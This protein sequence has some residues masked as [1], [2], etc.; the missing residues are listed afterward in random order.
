[1]AGIYW[2]TQIK[3][4]NPH[5]DLLRVSMDRL[6]NKSPG[7][8]LSQ[9]LPLT[10][11]EKDKIKQT[12]FCLFSLAF[13][14]VCVVQRC[15]FVVMFCLFIFVLCL[16]ITA[17]SLWGWFSSFCHSF[18]LSLFLLCSRWAQGVEQSIF[19]FEL[20]CIFYSLYAAF[21]VSVLVAFFFIQ[22]S[23]S[24]LQYISVRC[25]CVCL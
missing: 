9:G 2:Q 12:S 16:V 5:N 18:V 14:C 11:S 19:E 25:V 24:C 1:M 7:L 22:F 23:L 21:F 4:S 17:L 13:L 15:L 3:R 10:T 6:W 20:V 8:R